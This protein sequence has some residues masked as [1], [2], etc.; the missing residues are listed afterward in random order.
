MHTIY[1]VETSCVIEFY[2]FQSTFENGTLL[3][4]E[5]IISAVSRA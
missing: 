2:F 5:K 3:V 4:C 1:A